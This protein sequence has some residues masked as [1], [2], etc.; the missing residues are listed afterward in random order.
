MKSLCLLLLSASFWLSGCTGNTTETTSATPATDQTT[1][2][3]DTTARGRVTMFNLNDHSGVFMV[4]KA[5]VGQQDQLIRKLRMM[6]LALS[7]GANGP[8]VFAVHTFPTEPQT[9][10]VY[11]LRKGNRGNA[12]SDP[13]INQIKKDV[14]SNLASMTTYPLNTLFGKISN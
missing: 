1:T 5:K 6:N 9:V 10:Y 2:S 7:H 3:A 8:D 12:A 13:I 11:S 4:M 14:N